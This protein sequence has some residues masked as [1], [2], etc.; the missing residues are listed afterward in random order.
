MLDRLAVEQLDIEKLLATWRWLCPEK[1]VPVA[2]NAFGDLF[3]QDDS[4][5]VFWLDVAVGVF[6]KIAD[7]NT[8]FIEQADRPENRE[9]WF[10]ES[11]ERA[12]SVRGLQPGPMQ[13][14]GFSTPIIFEESGSPDSLYIADLRDYLG[15]L[16][17]LHRQIAGLPDGAK[18]QLKVVR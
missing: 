17:D 12:A 13:C 5:K 18:V 1:L 6:D 8:Q 2:R 9:N 11:D 7:S 16:G 4:G 3:L 14:I 10:A 15:F